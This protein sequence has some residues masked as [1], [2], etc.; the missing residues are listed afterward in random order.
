M[1]ATHARQGHAGESDG[2]CDVA[3]VLLLLGVVLKVQL[4]DV[5]AAHLGPALLSHVVHCADRARHD[6]ASSLALHATQGL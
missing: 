3:R 6:P 1:L 4:A 2:V 5:V